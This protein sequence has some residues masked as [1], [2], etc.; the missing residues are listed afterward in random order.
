[1]TMRGFIPMA[2]AAI[3]LA[4]TACPDSAA[5]G[6]DLPGDIAADDRAD[7]PDG[8]TAFDD[9]TVPR[10]AT[11][12]GFLAYA[13][14]QQDPAEVK[15]IIRGF[16]EAAPDVHFEE[17]TFYAMHDEWSW[18]RLLNGQSIPN[19]DLAPTT[20]LSFG[21]LGEILAWAKDQATLPLDLQWIGARLYSDYFY[22]NCF[23]E[24]RFFATGAV[25]HYAPNPAR[26]ASG[27][28]WLFELEFMDVPS[29][30][31]LT[32]YFEI[33]ESVMP[34]DVAP[35]LVWLT[36]GVGQEAVAA[37]LKASDSPY[38]DRTLNQEDLVVAGD[39]RGYN[40]G[41]AAGRVLV[42]PKGGVL[43][44]LPRPTDVLVLEEIPDDLP[45]VAAILTAVPQTPLAHIGILAKS[46]GTPNAYVAG[47]A[48]RQ[49]VA[50]WAY[51]R[52]PIIVRVTE[53]GVEL[54]EATNCDRVS[55]TPSNPCNREWE[56]YTALLGQVHVDPLV[57]ADL[58][59]APETFD[60]TSVGL[61]QM[62]GM[63]PLL[64][65]KSAGFLGLRDAEGIVLPDRPF[66]LTVKGYAQHLASLVP[67]LDTILADE[68]FR[69]DARVRALVLEGRDAFLTRFAGCTA[70]ASVLAAFDVV[71]PVGT[72]LGDAVA[73]GGVRRMIRNAPMEAGYLARITDALRQ[74]FAF[75]SH[76]QGLRFRSSSTA[77]DVEGFGGA[78]LYESHTAYLYPE[79][80]TDSGDRAKT[81]EETVKQ[82]WA[83][84][85]LAS[86]FDERENAGIAHL[87]GR[88]GIAIHPVF[89]DS[90]EL[91]NGVLML[92]IVRRAGGDLHTMTV[93]AQKGFLSVTNPPAGSMASPEID[94]VRR[95]GTGAVAVQR[96]QS[97]SEVAPGTWL[98]TDGELTLLLDRL[99]LLAQRWMDVRNAA[100]EAVKGPGFAMSTIT[101][102]VEFKRM[103]AGWP[104]RADGV[105]DPER[106]VIKQARTLET[107][108]RGPTSVVSLRVPRDVLGMVSRVE[109]RSCRDDWFGVVATELYTDPARTFPFDYSH[110]PY[111]VAFSF[112]MEAGDTGFTFPPV[113]NFV[114]LHPDATTTYP[115]VAEG[116]PW[117]L[118]L[119][120]TDPSAWGF[121]HVTVE[122]A[123]AWTIAGA[124][125]TLSG[126]GPPCVVSPLAQDPRAYLQG[127]L[128]GE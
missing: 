105:Q 124:P 25:L 85:W 108:L 49:D 29:L 8:S 121:S 99:A 92:E 72:A 73:K 96:T 62:P 46:R 68:K 94:V 107:A 58:A 24:Q 5:P 41:I 47:I 120:P 13:G 33:L 26:P 4:A 21:T 12:D 15:F 2:L 42:V 87:D 9:H 119:V 43:C 86:A 89:T 83:T 40:P 80:Q 37:Q 19:Y 48:Q 34:T 126:Q 75:L 35:R 53:D 51:Y 114:L 67:P 116:G 78:G 74:R 100:R 16:G 118:D 50:T 102:D 6:V 117:A 18:F 110:T 127:V 113:N 79:E 109:R 65:G 38:R 82:V 98:L 63:V 115:G 31:V 3:L 57:P 70:A 88:M 10:F 84:Y 128:D 91:A 27:E 14:A 36:R 44:A 69:Q 112:P 32:R 103:A 56:Q 76:A 23:G 77:E 106:M 7:V 11:A 54:Q 20:G 1:M 60:L 17:P 52:T 81:I 39:V 61:E 71:R 123:G 95:T 64:G 111:A 104:T 59:D 90:K 122:Q 66:A 101:L 28:L 97:S 125:G 55:S 22:S 30:A 45:P 93:N